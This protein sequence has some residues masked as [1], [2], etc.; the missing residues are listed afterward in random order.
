MAIDIYNQRWS[1]N[2]LLFL[3]LFLQ[4]LQTTSVEPGPQCF[5]NN[6]TCIPITVKLCLGASLPIENT[7]I[8]LAADSNS[9]EEIYEKLKLWSG[10]ENAPQC[11]QVVQPFLCSVYLPKCDAENEKVELP[12]RELCE[13]TREPCKIVESFHNGWPEFLQCDQPHF[14]TGCTTDTYEGL[15]FNTSGRCEYPLILTENKDSWFTDVP[16]CGIPCQNPLF[17][18]QEHDEVHAFIAVFGCI[19]LVCTLFTVLTFIIDWKNASRYPALILFYINACFFVG[20]IGWLAQFAGDAR[21]DIVCRSDGTARMGEPRL[22][23]GSTSCT[24]VFLMVYYTMMAGVIWFVMLA[25]SWHL[26]FKS[27]GTPTDYLSSK[28][29]YFHLISWLLPLVL[30]IICLSMSE[31]DGDS[32]SGICFVGYMKHGIRAGFVLTPIAVVLITGL[33][34]LLKGLITLIKIRKE[35]NIFISP[36]ATSKIRETILRLGIFSC[37]ALFFVLVTFSVHVYTFANENLWRES[38]TSYYKCKANVTIAHSDNSTESCHIENHPSIVAMEIHIFAFFGAGIVMSSW[39]WNKSTLSSWERFLRM[40]FRKPSNKPVKL[41][42]HKMIAQAFEKRRDV[43]NGRMSISFHST[44][45]DPLGM[46]FDLDS[47]SS[48]DMSSNFAAAMP[49]LVR[50]RG[51]L[52]HPVA[53]TGRRYSDSDV[54]SVCSRR[55][56]TDSQLG[57][58]PSLAEFV[59]LVNEKGDLKKKKKKKRRRSKNNKIQPKVELKNNKTDKYDSDTSL[60]SQMS[61]HNVQFSFE[62]RSIDALSLASSVQIPSDIEDIDMPPETIRNPR[63]V[64]KPKYDIFTASKFLPESKE[65][66][67]FSRHLQTVNQKLSDL[68]IE[69][70]DTNFFQGLSNHSGKTSNFTKRTKRESKTKQPPKVHESRLN[71]E[72]ELESLSD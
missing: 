7:S 40:V 38:Y 63:D 12:S 43:N 64:P 62:R 35:A 22:G 14:V 34:F 21:Q 48:H 55:M 6:S 44:H 31:I 61:T 33:F 2:A 49:K 53:G 60:R 41:K 24:I 37:L 20:S 70:T 17:S 45:D 71:V 1:N 28:T 26:T 13:R 25:Y 52:I 47:A 65:V 23:S 18:Q 50:R 51:G 11:W 66:S 29:A 57:I 15:N 9:L 4:F 72:P 32:L 30:S 16:G 58:G 46:K 19:C 10:L 5:Q 3:C 69:M 8:S 54:Q 59:A 27:L 39:S 67:K 68:K 36:K 42:K 56:S